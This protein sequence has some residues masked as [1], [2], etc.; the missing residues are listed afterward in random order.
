MASGKANIGT[1]LPIVNP[2]SAVLLDTAVQGLARKQEPMAN[3][4]AT[5]SGW[6]EAKANSRLGWPDAN[7]AVRDGWHRV[8]RAMPGDAD[9]DG[10]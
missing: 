3:Q 1:S 10:R 4:D 9:G 7:D 2:T 5:E 6:D 8:E